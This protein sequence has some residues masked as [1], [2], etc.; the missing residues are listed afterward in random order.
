MSAMYQRGSLEEKKRKDQSRKRVR[1]K[2][3]KSHSEHAEKRSS[4]CRRERFRDRT[5]LPKG[6]IT[7]PPNRGRRTNCFIVKRGGK[8]PSMGKK[9]DS[10]R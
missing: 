8:R 5:V 1:V 9:F 3:G 2:K 4:F 7:P 10:P 6:V